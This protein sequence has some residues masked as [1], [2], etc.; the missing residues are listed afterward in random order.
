MGF[1]NRIKN[2][3]VGRAEDEA[4]NKIRNKQTS[5]GYNQPQP[6][7]RQDP[8]SEARRAAHQREMEEQAMQ[9]EKQSMQL[10]SQMM[11]NQAKLMEESAKAM[12]SYNNSA[13]K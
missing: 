13:K 2:A 6:E 12:E 7:T 8:A 4:V 5:S 1:L 10:S 9:L 11:Q 3:V